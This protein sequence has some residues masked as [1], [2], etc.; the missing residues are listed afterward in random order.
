MIKF[1]AGIAVVAFTT[2]CGYLLA[3][4]YRKRRL[5]FTQLQTFNERFLSE[6]AYYRR[7]LQVFIREYNYKEEFALLLQRFLSCIKNEN[8]LKEVELF[9][10]SFF[11]LKKE[12]RQIVLNYFSMLGRGDSTAQK[13]YFS[14]VKNNLISMQEECVITCKKYADLYIKLGFLFG[15][16]ILILIV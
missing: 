7:P 9:G 12:E 2:F 16:L 10:E 6:L 5:F 13:G 15:L 14:A 8:E 11:F 3:G 4:K 1:F